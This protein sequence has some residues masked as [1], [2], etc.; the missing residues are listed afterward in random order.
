MLLG[1]ALLAC[2]PSALLAEDAVVAQVNG[3]DIKQSDLDF[4]T[5]EVG[6][7]LANIPPEDRRMMLLQFVIE[8]QLMADAAAKD[9]LD[10]APKLRGSAQISPPPDAARRIL[11]QERA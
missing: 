10:K 5:S 11:R 2:L 6:A 3:T 9:G 8:N 1:A 7:Q 4:A